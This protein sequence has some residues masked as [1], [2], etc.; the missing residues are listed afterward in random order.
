[1]LSVTLLSLLV[2]E[3]RQ[4]GL[5]IAFHWNFSLR[6]CSSITALQM[7]GAGEEQKPSAQPWGTLD[8]LDH[9][10]GRGHAAHSS[11]LPRTGPWKTVMMPY[12]SWYFLDS[13]NTTGTETAFQKQP[14]R[15]NT[16]VTLVQLGQAVNRI[17]TTSQDA[18]EHKSTGSP[19]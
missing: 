9:D 11:S 16:Q 1:M 15:K 8:H 13:K 3:K 5:Q 14:Q 18:T 2:K 10:L 19:F 17:N 7:A 4:G 6:S 12:S